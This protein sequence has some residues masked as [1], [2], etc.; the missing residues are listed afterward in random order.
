MNPP[1]PIRT[2]A[3]PLGVGS[4]IA[5]LIAI[6]GVPFF[7]YIALFFAVD[8]NLLFPLAG[9]LVGGLIHGG[10]LV[11]GFIA[12]FRKGAGLLPW[13]GIILNGIACIAI[14]LILL[15]VAFG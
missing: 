4:F 6:L 14:V 2:P 1:P 12:L 8:G 9:A 7:G 15:F 10:A 3:S 11:C 5:G 13:A